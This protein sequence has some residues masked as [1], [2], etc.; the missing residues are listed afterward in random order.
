MPFIKLFLSHLHE[1][2]LRLLGRPVPKPWIIEHGGHGH[3]IAPPNL[4]VVG[5]EG[6]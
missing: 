1:V 4:E 6:K 5:L 2:W 3:Y